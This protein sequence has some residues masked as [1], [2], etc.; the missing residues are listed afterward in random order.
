M[1]RR[2]SLTKKNEQEEGKISSEGAGEFKAQKE[3]AA[4]LSLRKIVLKPLTFPT[5]TYQLPVHHLAWSR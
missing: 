3:T 2:S 4:V 1:N 5:S